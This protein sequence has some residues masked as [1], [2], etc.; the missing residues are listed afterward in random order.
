[1]ELT[2]S[3]ERTGCYPSITDSF[4]TVRYRKQRDPWYRQEVEGMTDVSRR[5]CG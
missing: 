5:L 1:M 3:V 2:F 4:G